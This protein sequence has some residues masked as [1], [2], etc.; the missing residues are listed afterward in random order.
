[1]T[2]ASVHLSR[3][4][5]YGIVGLATNV[6]LYLVFLLLISGGMPPV[7]ASATCYVLGVAM[8][9]LLNR[10]WTFAS[11]SPHR[12]DLPR[13]LLAYLVG[14]VVTLAAMALLV[15]PLGAP[16]AQVLTIGVTALAIYGV[17]HLLRFGA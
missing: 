3:L 7:L 17:L 5:K 1:M 15:G 13:F 12:R 8:S 4:G 9:Y 16:L 6:S 2:G 10:R 11:A 14:L